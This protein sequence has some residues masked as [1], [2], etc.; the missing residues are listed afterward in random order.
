MCGQA[1]GAT[2][3]TLPPLLEMALLCHHFCLETMANEGSGSI[4]CAL[5]AALL[6]NSSP[7][8]Y[9][10]LFKSGD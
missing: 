10:M 6:D 8:C 7:A 1:S 4:R 3:G 5:F 2:Q 9:W